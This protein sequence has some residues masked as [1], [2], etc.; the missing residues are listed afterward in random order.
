MLQQ[1]P[2]VLT[3]LVERNVGCDVLAARDRA[4]VGL[5]ALTQSILQAMLP[6]V[7]PLVA[8]LG[9]V[10]LDDLVKTLLNARVVSGMDQHRRRLVAVATLIPACARQNKGVDRVA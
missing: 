3:D 10:P 7:S 2:D 4:E 6:V 9:H 1:R 5:P 8:Q